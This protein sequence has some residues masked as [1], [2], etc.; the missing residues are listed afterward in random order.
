MFDKHPTFASN[1]V[2]RGAYRTRQTRNKRGATLGLIIACGFGL[3]FCIWGFFQLSMLMG[4]SRQVRNAV[5]AGALNVSK[6]IVEVKV[7]VSPQYADCG[8]STGSVS[9]SNINRIW[10]KAF[11]INANVD[12]M[13]L[14]GQTSPQATAAAETAYQMSKNLNDDLFSKVTCHKVL[15]SLFQQLAH[16]REARLLGADTKIEKTDTDVCSVAMVDRGAESNLAYNP[17]Q[18][19]TNVTAQG[20]S[21]GPK[22]FL[23]GYTPMKANEKEFIFTSFRMGEMP[24]LIGDDYFEKNR[25]DTAPLG[26]SY[27][28]VPNAFRRIGEVDAMPSKVTATA[29]AVAN[30]Q[31][32]YQMAI[33]YSF[34]TIQ[35]GNTAKW[36]VEKKKIKETT[37]GFKPETQ[38]EVK[39]VKLSTGGTVN[40]WGELGHEYAS[41]SSLLAVLNALPGD[42]SVPFKKMLQRLQEIDPNFNMTRLV[43]LLESQAFIPQEGQPVSKYYLYPVYSSPDKSDP[44]IKIGS[45]SYDLPPWLNPNNPPEGLEKVVATENKQIDKPNWCYQRITGGNNSSGKHWTEVYGNIMW[46]PG[47]GFGQHLGELRFARVTELYFSGDPDS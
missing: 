38:Y 14:D 35:V 1:S 21:L 5:D 30:P 45:S 9:M 34:V 42:H 22:S 33:P 17:N 31:R 3:M 37:Y 46:Q 44:T 16:Q 15:N 8:D 2:N 23:R 24:H 12:G 10:G 32:S 13:K 19:P 28:P 36:Y 29:C 7:P 40:G 4:G 27:T 43:K 26:G 25:A 11:L 18:L 41:A 20:L 39:D 6:R 47:T